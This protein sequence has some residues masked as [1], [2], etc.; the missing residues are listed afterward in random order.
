MKKVMYDIN[1]LLIHSNGLIILRV[2]I[3]RGKV[4]RNHMERQEMMKA[5]IDEI[6]QSNV[7]E[8]MQILHMAQVIQQLRDADDRDKQIEEALKACLKS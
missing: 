2:T 8:Q 3:N 7:K 1:V 4:W 5:L 6:K